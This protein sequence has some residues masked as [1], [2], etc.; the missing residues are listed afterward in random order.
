M[1]PDA[2]A[3]GSSNTHYKTIS[4]PIETLRLLSPP[5]FRRCCSG[6]KRSRGPIGQ[7]LPAGGASTPPPPSY[8]LGS[9]TSRSSDVPW[10]YNPFSSISAQYHISTNLD[11][12]GILAHVRSANI[13]ELESLLVL[14]SITSIASAQAWWVF[15]IV[16]Y[17][18]HSVSKDELH[19][20]PLA[21]CGFFLLKRSVL[22][23]Y[24][25]VKNSENS[26]IYVTTVLFHVFPNKIFVSVFPQLYSCVSGIFRYHI[27][28]SFYEFSM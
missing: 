6:V 23:S 10:E 8:W 2:S 20:F 25:G 16:T 13:M 22:W 5:G 1:S 19:G 24:R 15:T 14:F 27:P 7:R 18:E 12:V 9:L 11:R 17:K 26:S 3:P 21:A 28:N 4:L